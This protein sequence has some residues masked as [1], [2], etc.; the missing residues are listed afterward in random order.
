MTKGRF[1]N[2]GLW[3]RQLDTG[4]IQPR[5]LRSVLLTAADAMVMGVGRINGELVGKD[6]ARCIA[7]SYD[8]S[9]L[10]GTQGNKK[11]PETGPHVRYS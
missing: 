2:M 4:T 8:Y 9:V 10:A 7:M 1:L 3:L 5:S 11:P 6:N